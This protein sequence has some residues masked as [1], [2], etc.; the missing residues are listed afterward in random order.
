ME[1][2]LERIQ[3]GGAAF[4]LSRSEKF[5]TFQNAAPIYESIW[6][7]ALEGGGPAALDL[8]ALHTGT[9]VPS[10]LAC[11]AR[12]FSFAQKLRT[13]RA[14]GREGGP[15]FV[16][17]EFRIDTAVDGRRLQLLHQSLEQRIVEK[18]PRR[19][20]FFLWLHLSALSCEQPDRPTERGTRQDC[21]LP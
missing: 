13:A 9:F 20:L 7:K 1:R 2:P 5:A 19:R 8:R 16:V 15:R 11:S 17:R 21:L 14:F 4:A 6:H 12:N 18:R 3:R 10:A